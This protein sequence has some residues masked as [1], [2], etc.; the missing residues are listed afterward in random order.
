[1]KERVIQFGAD[2]SLVGIL[3]EPA[4]DV[5]RSPAPIVVMSNVGLNHRVGPSRI[6]VKLA[7]RLAAQGLTSF[8]FDVSGLGDSAPRSDLLG[9][10]ERSV[11][12]L[13]DAL[14]MLASEVGQ[15]FVLVSLCSGTDNAHRV[16]TVDPRVC[17]AV[18]LDGYTYTTPRF[19]LHQKGMRFV[20]RPH[21]RRWI[22]R[23][24]P[25]KFGLQLETRTAGAANEIFSR[26]YPR[27]DQFEAD[28]TTIV[29]R[30]G[31][32]FFVF[33]GETMYA[34]KGQFWDWLD[35]KDWKG[36]ISLEYYP[37]ANHTYTFLEDREIMLAAVL[38]WILSLGKSRHIDA[39]P[40]SVDFG[41]PNSERARRRIGTE[42]AENPSIR[43]RVSDEGSNP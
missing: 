15:L 36:Q 31:H 5:R 11:L 25:E 34:Y 13:H 22:K 43:L 28:I 27:R 16:A 10:V 20:S 9:D 17:G 18:F 26:E 35:R 1:M 37:K 24:F 2:N 14:S 42:L 33:S 19:L 12:D 30:G 41:S 8:R 23:S 29:D 39:A 4:P 38:E 6:W 21:W 40:T 32:L 3:T 7:R